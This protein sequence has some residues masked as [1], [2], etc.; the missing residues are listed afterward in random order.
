MVKKLSPADAGCWVD[1][2]WGQYAVA[3]MTQIAGQGG[4]DSQRIL[5]LADRHLASQTT[6]DTGL[7]P[8]ESEELMDASDSA[9]QW[10]N[11]HLAPEGYLF[12]WEDGEFW[13]L[14]QEEWDQINVQAP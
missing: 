2:H 10:M 3:R 1:G 8:D 4:Y 7:T 14:S 11:E 9:E 12:S 6:G 13:L 5:D